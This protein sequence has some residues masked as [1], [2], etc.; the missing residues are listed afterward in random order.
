MNHSERFIFALD[1]HD[2]TGK[3]TLA[4][5]LASALGGTYIRPYGEPFGP[6]LLQ[7]AEAK[8]YNTVIQVGKQAFERA[9]VEAPLTGPLIFDRLWI[10]VFTLVPE[11]YHCQWNMRP[12]TAVCW[13]DLDT[14]L[15]RLAG[16]QEA[17]CERQW[18]EYYIHL[19]QELSQKYQCEFIP[20]HQLDEQQAL[21]RLVIWAQHYLEK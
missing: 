15:A 13:V 2:G 5:R 18:H 9:T 8:D 3:T 19:Y 10:T 4:Q 21:A 12:P 6:A 7:A 14:T 11:S 17:I 16:R 20:T 1:G